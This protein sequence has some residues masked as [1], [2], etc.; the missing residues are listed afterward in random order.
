MRKD[1]Q[2]IQENLEWTLSRKNPFFP[3]M[4]VLPFIAVGM[5]S[6]NLFLSLKTYQ[7]LQA[8]AS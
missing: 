7:K 6:L 1:K 3:L 2:E 5:L 8:G 4:P